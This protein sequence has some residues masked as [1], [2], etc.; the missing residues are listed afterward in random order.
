M[1]TWEE[2][3]TPIVQNAMNRNIVKAKVNV[4]VAKPP[5]ISM[6]SP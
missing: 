1:E 4:S 6:K 5:V 3:K 2:A